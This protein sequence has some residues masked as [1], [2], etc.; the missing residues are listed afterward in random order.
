VEADPPPG[1]G[2]RL[3]LIAVGDIGEGNGS[4]RRNAEAMATVCRDKAD[5]HG[6]G[7]HMLLTLGDNLYPEG[8]PSPDSPIWDTNLWSPWAPVVELG[9]PVYAT[10]GNH[11]YGER[12]FSVERASHQLAHSHPLWN[13]P[14]RHYALTAGPVRLVALDT[15]PILLEPLWGDSPQRAWVDEA[16]SQGD[17]PW[18]LAFG[19][20]PYRSNGQ[21]GNAGAYEGKE[22]LPIVSGDSVADF[23]EAHLC[24]RADLVLS[25]HDHNRQWLA[26]TC[27]TRF[28]VSGAASKTTPLVDRGAPSEWADDALEGF[29]WL[30]L[31]ADGTG[32]A[33]FWDR[34]GTSNFQVPLRSRT[35]P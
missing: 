12:G 3:R 11:D 13:L 26:P 17:A 20:H 24:G 7:C 15:N 10:L 33:E 32:L 1:I 5:H 27:G 28:A 2:D 19:H 21:H 22:W 4:Q 29:I 6:L 30:E 23:M 34:S 18:K 35:A 14:A 9:L 8:A 31:R 16:L 25:G